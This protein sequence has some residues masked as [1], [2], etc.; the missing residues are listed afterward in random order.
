MSGK[1]K[2]GC[3]YYVFVRDKNTKEKTLDNNDRLKVYAH[4][5]E[6]AHILAK[7]W[8]LPEEEIYKVERIPPPVTGKNIISES[9]KAMEHEAIEEYFRSH[10]MNWPV[11]QDMGRVKAIFVTGFSF[12]KKYYEI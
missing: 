2:D 3:F 7:I 10:N 4:S 12:C 8:L 6:E 9:K 5:D 11:T 1:V